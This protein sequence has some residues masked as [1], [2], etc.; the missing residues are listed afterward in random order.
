MEN[1]D[2]RV[3]Y[4][5]TQQGLIYQGSKDYIVSIPW[6]FG[7]VSC[8]LA[9]YGWGRISQR[10]S[11]CPTKSGGVEELQVPSIKHGHLV[12]PHFLWWPV[13]SQDLKLPSCCWPSRRP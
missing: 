8:F 13:S 10:I 3:E 2:D 12:G 5:L 7:Q 4:V 6:N 11:V 1:N 9:H